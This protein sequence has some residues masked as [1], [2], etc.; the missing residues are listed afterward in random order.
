MRKAAFFDRDG[1][2][3]VNTGHLYEPEKLQFVPGAP[4]LI[5][6]YK[7]QGYLIIVATNQA[8]IAKGYYSEAQMHRLHE[9]MNF[10]LLNEYGTCIDHFYFCPHH[11]DYT[12]P[13]DC[14][15]PETGMLRRA[16]EE[17][18]IDCSRSVLFGDKPSDIQCGEKVGIKSFYIQETLGL[19]D[20]SQWDI[21]ADG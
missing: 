7:E 5:R 15:K 13:C 19:T 21:T 18:Q 17:H 9:H 14:R 8:G 20:R 10:R 16:V 4:E 12:G 3:N 1:T 6:D 11:P 2:I